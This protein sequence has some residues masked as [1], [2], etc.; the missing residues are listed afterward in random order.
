[1]NK[2]ML[3]SQISQLSKAGRLAGLFQ[4]IIGGVL[5]YYY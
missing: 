3:Q 4:I 2:K 1:M 5:Q